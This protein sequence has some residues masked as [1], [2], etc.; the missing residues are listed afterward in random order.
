MKKNII[1]IFLLFGLIS[2]A[3]FSEDILAGGNSKVNF[4]F[5]TGMMRVVN[6]AN[7]NNM[8]NIINSIEIGFI[9]DGKPLKLKEI[10]SKAEYIPGTAVIRVESSY[11]KLIFTTYILSSIEKENKSIF[12]VNNIKNTDIK[13]DRSVKAFVIIDSKER[14]KNIEFDELRESYNEGSCFI[15]TINSKKQLYFTDEYGYRE[16]KFRKYSENSIKKNEGEYLFFLADIENIERY[17]EKRNTIEISIDN[18]E[19]YNSE[20]DL[21]KE[22]IV[23]REIGVWGSWN[24]VLD[25]VETEKNSLNNMKQISV[26][27][28]LAIREDGSVLPY[29]LRENRIIKS[30]DMIFTAIAMLKAKHFKE[31]KKII[32]YINN[33]EKS[34]KE[35]IIADFGY[36]IDTNKEEVEIRSDGKVYSHYI[37]SLYLYLL[38]EYI[39][40]SGDMA[41]FRE[42]YKSLLKKMAESLASNIK[43]GLV[44]KECYNGE[45]GSNAADYY[46]NSNIALIESYK[47]YLKICDFYIPENETSI[48][49][50]KLEE[51]K[52]G[53]Q[54]FVID[55][56]IIDSLNSKVIKIRN[57]FAMKKEYF[58]HSEI[59]EKSYK[60]YMELLFESSIQNEGKEI[61]E[62]YIMAAIAALNTENKKEYIKIKNSIDK[63]ITENNGVLPEYVKNLNQEKKYGNIGIDTRVNAMYLFMKINGGVYGVEK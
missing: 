56:V 27:L 14:E 12:I 44:Q 4:G 50:L 11:Q 38:C 55:G 58:N 48:E 33:S 46:L 31:T 49:R 16:L 40:D 60:K 25:G 29:L 8:K 52:K 57:S 21:E 37:D 28:K 53:I 51:V 43:D 45:V 20:E 7:T 6:V 36:E 26:M 9:V 1:F 62:Y 59:L 13:K 61:M 18:T 35:N 10:T 63:V 15:R 3:V 32:D 23:D 47:S 54:K 22:R 39:N 19:V 41:F 2:A 34:D 30:E 24:S 42:N 17:S 5:D